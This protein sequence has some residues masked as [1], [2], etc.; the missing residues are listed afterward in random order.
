MKPARIIALL[1]SNREQFRSM[2]KKT[3]TLL[4][5][6]EITFRDAEKKA[7]EVYEPGI[8]MEMGS[9]RKTC[10]GAFPTDEG[11]FFKRRF[12]E[13]NRGSV[14][15]AKEI[16]SDRPVAAVDGSQIYPSEETHP[17]VG[18][19]NIAHFINYHVL[20]EGS[21]ETSADLEMILP[22]EEMGFVDDASVNFK[23]T[24]AEIRRTTKMLE[25]FSEFSIGT[26]FFDERK[27][28]DSIGTPEMP[29]QQGSRVYI[30]PMPLG[31]FDGSLVL[32]F[33]AH[34]ADERRE[35][36]VSAITELLHTSKRCAVPVCGYIDTSRARDLV[37]ML[38]TFH[39]S[40]SQATDNNTVQEERKGEPPP[41][42]REIPGEIRGEGP[43]PSPERTRQTE[44][45]SPPDPSYNLPDEMK[46][47]GA[48]LLLRKVP[49]RTVEKRL[50][51]PPPSGIFDAAVLDGIMGPWSRTAAFVA[52]RNGILDDYGGLSRQ[53]CFCYARFN[54]ALPVRLEF[55]RWIVDAGLVD[56]LVKSCAAQCV[57]GGGYPYVLKRAHDAAVVREH[58]R[59]RFMR[60]FTAFARENGAGMPAPAKAVAKK[61]K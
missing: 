42:F 2:T 55:P 17:P 13:E 6:W 45:E 14:E 57:V 34:I 4:K 10:D 12:R 16:L 40:Y 11:M 39:I 52:C 33:A 20:K 37:T 28:K 23:R 43:A 60:M 9:L 15:W 7:K 27:S 54:D 31:F 46:G 29:F 22:S 51:L 3:N 47:E 25:R 32:S 8:S 5:E 1:E 18:V 36:L 30:N 50:T 58:D 59:R 48:A 53:V 19:V 26:G 38:N 41:T 35:T 49:D 21:Y 24:L 44:G 61:R 56:D